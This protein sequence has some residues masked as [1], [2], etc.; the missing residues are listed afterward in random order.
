MTFRGQQFD[1]AYLHQELQGLLY[2]FELRNG[3]NLQQLIEQYRD[4]DCKLIGF[5]EGWEKI[6]LDK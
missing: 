6:L 4:V 2:I 5:C 1:P 3:L